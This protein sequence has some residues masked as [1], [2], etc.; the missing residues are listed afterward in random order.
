MATLGLMGFVWAGAWL[1]VPVAGI[2]LRGAAAATL[3]AVAVGVFGIGEC[4]H[5][6]VQEPLV[7]DLAEPDLIGRYMALSALS[8]QVG[9]MLGPAVGGFAIALSPH[10]IWLAAAAICAANGILA[11]ALEPLLPQRARR[12]PQAAAA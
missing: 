3:L 9:F 5:G 11:L 12:T 4:L 10:G 7:T 6:T 8:W 2:W 1:L